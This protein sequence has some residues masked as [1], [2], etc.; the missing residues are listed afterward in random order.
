MKRMK[1]RYIFALILCMLFAWTICFTALAEET[2]VSRETPLEE[3]ADAAETDFSAETIRHSL[4]GFMSGWAEGETDRLYRA[5]FSGWKDGNEDPAQA[6]N[7]ILE[8]GKPH[9]YKVNS[10]SGENG[11]AI[12]TVS[13]T[14]QR[15]TGD[16]G[17]AFSL[18]EIEFRL[19]E[20]DGYYALD[21]D[22]FGKQG[23]PAEPVPEEEMI[24]LPTNPI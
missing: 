2:N 19:E 20:E 15:G 5:C 8:T 16:G 7:K 24:V 18:Y 9:G 1:Y 22:G 11:D 6:M 14:L 21:P 23:T 3:T 4:W 17:Y 13:V 10:I 12:R